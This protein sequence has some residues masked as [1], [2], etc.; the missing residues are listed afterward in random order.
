MESSHTFS[1]GYIDVVIDL[2]ETSQVFQVASGFI[3]QHTLHN[4]YPP[5]S[6]I[7]MMQPW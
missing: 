3:V 2:M 6:S 7:S 1:C 4:M 5:S